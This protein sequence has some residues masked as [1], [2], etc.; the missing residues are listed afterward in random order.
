MQTKLRPIAVNIVPD[1]VPPALEEGFALKIVRIWFKK[2]GS[3]RY[4]SHLDL[5]RC[6]SR[7]I[8]RSKIPL[9][10]TQGFHQHAFITFAL[11]LSLGM[12]GERESMDIK[13]EGE[14]SKEDLIA[15]LNS[16]LPPD[17]PVFD[18]T[19][20]VMKP[21]KIA[22]ADYR[23]AIFSDCFSACEI[24]K[25]IIEILQ[26]PA[27]MATK[28]TKSGAITELD[29]KPFLSNLQIEM[30]A[31]N[32]L[33]MTLTLPAGSVQNINPGLLTELLCSRMETELYFEITRTNLYDNR[34]QIFL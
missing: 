1:V 9:W 23:I 12:S 34:H 4:I 3:A 31:E 27:L 21:G 26:S 19:E 32:R 14:I 13:L 30:P 33:I 29:L 16:V 22:F 10:Y 25:Q 20:P 6:M 18:V 17:I 8:H 7:A 15:R 5:N 28:K 24:K 11:P 2:Q